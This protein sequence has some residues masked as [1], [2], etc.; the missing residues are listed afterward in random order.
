VTGFAAQGYTDPKE[1]TMASAYGGRADASKLSVLKVR[2]PFGTI[3]AAGPVGLKIINK[4]TN[5]SAASAP[6]CRVADFRE[7]SAIDAFIYA[8]RAVEET[9]SSNAR[10][11]I[12]T[13]E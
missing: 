10:Q 7:R 9:C 3:P 13:P 2:V 4:C 6:V 5:S 8:E 1:E 12:L 11:F